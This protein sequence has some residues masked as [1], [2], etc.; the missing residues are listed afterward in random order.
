MYP[1]RR[2]HMLVL[3]LAALLLLVGRPARAADEDSSDEKLLRAQKVAAD[4]PGLLAYLR[5]RTL[6]D[7]DARKLQTLVAQLGSDVFA[8][9]EQASAEL[10]RYGQLALPLLHKAA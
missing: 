5:S 4:G 7:A 3:L 9:R 10:I 8:E 2:R 1:T 6:E